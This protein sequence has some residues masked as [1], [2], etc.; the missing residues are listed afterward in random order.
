MPTTLIYR[1]FTKE[2]QDSLRKLTLELSTDP[3]K[4]LLDRAAVLQ[5]AYYMAEHRKNKRTQNEQ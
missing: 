4:S 3:T 2:E 5:M 1:Y